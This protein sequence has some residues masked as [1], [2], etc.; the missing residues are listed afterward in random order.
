VDRQFALKS[1]K[2]SLQRR[3]RYIKKKRKEMEK[4]NHAQA[5]ARRKLKKCLCNSNK[6]EISLNIFNKV[7]KAAFFLKLH[8]PF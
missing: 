7:N 5:I 4:R 2:P 6:D 8:G 1:K 3:K